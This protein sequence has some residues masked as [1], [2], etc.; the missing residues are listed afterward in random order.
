MKKLA[1]VLNAVASLVVIAA[2]CAAQG[3]ASSPIQ[4]VQ[5]GGHRLGS[6]QFRPLN[7]R[8]CPPG[9]MP[10]DPQSPQAPQNPMTPDQPPPASSPQP[11]ALP[12]ESRYKSSFG[13][14]ASVSAGN[15]IGAAI[16]SGAAGF[17]I[18]AA[19]MKVA[20]L[21]STPLILP[22]LFTA[23]S[24]QS[25]IPLDRVSFDYGYFD[26]F[27]ITTPQGVRPGFNLNQYSATI[28]KT[29]LDG[30]ASVYVNVP[31]LN[32]TQNQSGQAIDGLGDVSAGFKVILWQDRDTGSMFTGGFS[33]A[34][35]T[36]RETTITNTLLITFTGGPAPPGVNPP[37]VG[38]VIPVT[39]TTTINPT[40][41]QP[42]V[43]FLKSWDRLYVHEYFGVVVPT[44]NRVATLLNINSTVGYNVYSDPNRFIRSIT[45]T[46]GVQLL[47]PVNNISNSTGSTTREVDISCLTTTFPE[48]QLPTRLGFS[49]QVMIN[50]GA[51][52]GLGERCLLSLGVVTPVAGPRGY[53]V[54]GT[55][56]L[57]YF[58]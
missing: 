34:A 50:V 6:P 21:S 57:S 48:D 14:G 9:V 7:P 47:L 18:P 5:F 31:F 49:N 17:P 39:S 52:V 23:A 20:T 13:L 16:A 10:S 30:V 51:Q 55:I 45:P 19:N 2:P 33:V 26:R 32:A 25:V 37:P 12:T 40:Y 35:P 58:Y 15:G 54:G 29:L 24:A 27:A 28:E 43:G 11:D 22:G 42:W 38:T 3:P 8:D 1:W 41:L 46:L 44:D 4:P 53:A 36:A 56:G